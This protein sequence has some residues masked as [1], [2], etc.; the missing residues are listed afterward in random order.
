MPEVES[1]QASNRVGTKDEKLLTE[2]RENFQYDYDSFSSIREE[3]ARDV[4][5]IA[6]DAWLETEKKLRNTKGSERPMLNCDFL[7]QFCHL[8]INEVRQHPRE[9]KISPAGF[10]A[11]AE[12][13]ELRENRIRAIQYHSDAQAAYVTA[14]ENCVQ[15]SYGFGRV[16]LAYVSEKSFDQEIRIRRIPNPD[17][18]LFDAGCKELDCSDA[19]HCFVVDE[20]LRSEFRRRWPNAEVQDFDAQIAKDHPHWVKDKSIQIA[21]Y[22]RKEFT[23]DE[24][25][26]FDGGAA[27]LM[28]ELKS[29]L[30]ARG[31]RVED[32]TVIYPEQD[33]HPEIR[34]PLTNTRD[35]RVAKIRQYLTNGIEILE[36][37]E[38]VGK[39]IPI[40]PIFG[41]ELYLTEAGSSKR[42]LLSLIRN[43]R[44]AQR[45]FNYVETCKLEAIGQV[46]RTNYMA[47]EGQFEGH[48]TEVAEANQKPTPYLYYKAVQMPDGSYTANPPIREPFDPPVQ[49]LEIA[50]E[51]FLRAGQTAVGMYN[52]SVGRNDTNVKSGKAIQELDEQSDVGSFHFIA[53]YNRFIV[54]VGRIV[55]DLQSKIEITPRQVPIRMR[56]G[57]EKL[58]W[59]NKQYDDDEGKSQ[60][61][62]MTLGEYDVTINVGPNEDSQ[63]EEASDYLETLTE[64]LAAL[65]LDPAVKTQLLALVIQLKQMGPIG[66]QMVKILTPQTGDPAQLQQQMQTLQSQLQQLQTENSALHLDRAKRQLEADTKI[67]IERMKQEGAGSA[68]AAD[69]MNQQEL[70]KFNVWA[71]IIVAE[72]QKQSRST[73]QIA[74]QD[75]SKIEQAMDF[76][77]E[78]GIQAVDHA[79]EHSIADKQA[80]LARTQQLTQA[81]ADSASQQ[82]DQAHE[83]TQTA[84]GQAH[85]Q[86]MAQQAQENQPEAGQ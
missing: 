14:L 57:K 35:T 41:K 46:P 3:G 45:G 33:G 75:A 85:E 8:V 17:S 9:V 48:E 66:D 29:K 44:D 60:H 11:T 4:S 15:R 81:A 19:H 83:A 21:E 78:A 79:H 34:V 84:A 20:I 2:V 53:N 64:Q 67:E 23:D 18:V 52:S 55:N 77:H 40:I 6:N 10:G 82:S 36:D 47:I 59:I 37:H 13:A 61:H 58:V 68:D 70:A 5:F 22:W 54:A 71:K 43:A 25:L 26:Q 12:L 73:D 65:P 50:S 1:K 7:N 49:N 62:D 76:G 30:L 39:W 72:M 63:R 27:G 74:E 86:T 28:T 42:M 51:S 69:H 31:G 24:L 56:D 80:A 32:S 38:W 16:G